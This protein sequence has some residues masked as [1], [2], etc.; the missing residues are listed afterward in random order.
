MW[1]RVFDPVAAL[2]AAVLMLGELENWRRER[3]PSGRGRVRDPA[4]HEQFDGLSYWR[5]FRLAEISSKM[6]SYAGL[7]L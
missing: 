7:G 5:R 2:S 6:A 3:G 1:D 4:P